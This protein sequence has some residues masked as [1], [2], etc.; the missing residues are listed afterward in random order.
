MDTA[1]P[2]KADPSANRA[3]KSVEVPDE[4]ESITT[5]PQPAQESVGTAALPPNKPLPKTAS[6][7]NSNSPTPPAIAIGIPV[8]PLPPLPPRMAPLNPPTGAIQETQAEDIRQE[9]ASTL[10]APP[11][12]EVRIRLQEAAAQTSGSPATASDS[13]EGLKLQ[14]AQAPLQ[15]DTI[16]SGQIAIKP[17][18]QVEPQSIPVAIASAIPVGPP[19]QEIPVAPGAARAVSQPPQFQE[20]APEAPPES[21]TQA[22][23][24][25]S[26]SLEFTPDGASDVRLRLSERDGDVHIALHSTDPA[27]TGRLSEGVHDLA[28]SL[29][30]AGYDAQAWTPEHD[31]NGRQRQPQEETPEGRHS[32]T[33]DPDAED[34]D[35]AMQEPTKSF[36]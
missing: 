33:A 9:P 21:R 22:Q 5:L 34:F 8:L 18:L 15:A 4:S 31:R 30:N 3:N 10:T 23:P 19:P 26:V 36:L 2:A 1:P 7:K 25:R 11:A 24:L 20:A 14:A 12:L 17:A 35:T 27:L 32:P 28:A 6:E 13:A 16:P 29:V